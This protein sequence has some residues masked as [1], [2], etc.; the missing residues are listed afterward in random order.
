MK[1]FITPKV[2]VPIALTILSVIWLIFARQL[3]SSSSVTTFA[4]PST[5]PTLVLVIML[6]CSL[7][8]S[9]QEVRAAAQQAPDEDAPDRLLPIDIKRIAGFVIAIFAYVFVLDLVTFIPATIVL[10]VLLLL[11]FGQ[12]KPLV[13]IAVPVGFTLAIYAIFEF[14]L[15]IDLP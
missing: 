13:L 15:K 12:R 2:Y 9:I 11:L 8:V 1:R 7:V 3:P 4:G 10:L 5:F 6:V 14:A